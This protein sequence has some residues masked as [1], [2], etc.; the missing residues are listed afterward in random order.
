MQITEDNC[1][2]CFN[3]L[4]LCGGNEAGYEVAEDKDKNND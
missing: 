4:R 2:A 1:K 3:A